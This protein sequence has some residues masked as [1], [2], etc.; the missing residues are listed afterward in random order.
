MFRKNVKFQF[1]KF[2]FDFFKKDLS[3]D[4]DFQRKID[5]R[6]PRI[7]IRKKMFGGHTFGLSSF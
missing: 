1:L 6:R 7:K 4:F 3:E 2:K 5:V